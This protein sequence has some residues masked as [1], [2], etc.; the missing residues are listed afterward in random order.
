M[1][2][3][4][5]P[6]LSWK[7]KY[8]HHNTKINHIDITFCLFQVHTR[9]PHLYQKVI[10]SARIIY[11]INFSLFA[12]QNKLNTN[13]DIKEANTLINV[14][15]NKIVSKSNVLSNISGAK[16]IVYNNLMK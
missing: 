10:R 14:F 2:L 5:C 15:C 13:S 1:S 8:G 11:I 7:R 4:L 12:Y 16:N 9:F 6:T 3:A